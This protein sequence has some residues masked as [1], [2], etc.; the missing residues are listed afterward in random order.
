MNATLAEVARKKEF[1]VQLILMFTDARLDG[2]K[3]KLLRSMFRHSVVSATITDNGDNL[4]HTHQSA[5]CFVRISAL[6]Q[7]LQLLSRLA[8]NLCIGHIIENR[9]IVAHPILRELILH[10]S[11]FLLICT[12]TGSECG[13]LL[14]LNENLMLSSLCHVLQGLL[15]ASSGNRESLERIVNGR[16]AHIH[17]ISHEDV[18]E[19]ENIAS[20]TLHHH[21]GATVGVI[22]Q[23][24]SVAQWVIPATCAEPQIDGVTIETALNIHVGIAVVYLAV[25]DLLLHLRGCHQRVRAHLQHIV[26]DAILAVPV[27]DEVATIAIHALVLCHHL[28]HCLHDESHASS[29]R[30]N[31]QR[32]TTIRAHHIRLPITSF[33]YWWLRWRCARWNSWHLSHFRPKP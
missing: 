23:I 8:D 9:H 4:G 18:L 24:V 16:N 21:S 33:W 27:L 6:F 7:K 10:L 14:L 29:P 32:A 17:V 5:E 1:T 3:K 30:W 13:R 28:P 15:V 19:V 12:A 20:V 22:H 2:A 11:Q 31:Q 25:L 26:Q